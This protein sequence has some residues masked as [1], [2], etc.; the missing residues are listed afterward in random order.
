MKEGGKRGQ[1]TIFIILAILIIALALLIYF[2]YPKL[3]GG[4]GGDSD[5]PYS[6]IETCM[7]EKI[8]NTVETISLQGGSIDPTFYYSYEGEKVTY[9][10]YI[11]Q[12]YKPCVVQQAMLIPHIQSEI[13]NAIKEDTTFCFNSLKES[14]LKKGYDVSLTEVIPGANPATVVLGP[15]KVSTTFN[16]KLTLTKSETNTYENFQ[17]ILEDSIYEFANIAE[18]IISY[19]ALYGDAETT[20]YM[21]IYHDLKVEK[22]KQVDESSVYILTN[23]DSERKF[24][25]ASRSY[26]FPPGVL[27]EE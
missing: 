1:L 27:L 2:L 21:N 22:K 15:E 6:Y 18:S 14:Y 9:L 17:I 13:E 5:N 24:M 26:A 19:E 3:K 8:Q 12:Y 7:K 16:Y 23:R 25:F 20:N 11:N 4:G 10:C